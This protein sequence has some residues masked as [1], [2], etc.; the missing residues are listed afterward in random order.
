[1]S[2]ILHLLKVNG[3]VVRPNK[4]IFVVFKV[5]FLGYEISESGIRPLPSKVAAVSEFQIPI[6]VKGLQQ[7]IGMVSYCRRFLPGIGTTMAPLYEVLTGKSK[8]L[9]WGFAQ[10]HAFSAMKRALASSTT[11]SFPRPGPPLVLLLML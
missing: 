3:L 7:F 2:A 11:F 10:Q 9:L 6:T 4:C 8:T 5:E 1:M